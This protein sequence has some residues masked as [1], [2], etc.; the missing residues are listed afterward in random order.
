MSKSTDGGKSWHDVSTDLTND[1]GGVWALAI[2]P[3]DP[4]TLYAG[5]F[6]NGVFKSTNS[7]TNWSPASIGLTR[8]IVYALAIDPATPTTLYA[9]TEGGV[10]K[11]TNGSANWSAI[12]T[13]LPGGTSVTSLA[14]D[15]ATSTTL[16]A[17]TWGSGVFK[18]TDG[19]AN[20]NALNTGLPHIGV[21]P[22]TRVFALVFDPANPTTLY[23]GTSEGIF[24][25][26]QVK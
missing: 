22:Y 24:V 2:D 9:G 19:G 10:F 11:S 6:F 12:N 8:H 14:I 1:D 17:V 25:I 7:G 21:F 5:T 20:W 18:S 23:A 3:A 4:A 26:H 16:Y 15:P 13:G